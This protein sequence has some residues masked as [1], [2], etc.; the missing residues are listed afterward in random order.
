MRY[1]YAL[2]HIPTGR[3]LPR[4]PS[5][6]KGGSWVE[7]ADPAEDLPRFFLRERDA[8]G[9]LTMWLKGPQVNMGHTNWEDGSVEYVPE[10]VPSKAAEPRIRIE[11]HVVKIEWR[12]A[13]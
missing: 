13:S 8:K 2:E 1:L 6:Q 9:F 11:W 12:I 10:A 5:G 4:P 3:M 7:P